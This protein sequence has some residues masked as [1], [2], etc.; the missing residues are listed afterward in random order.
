[1]FEWFSTQILVN[2]EILIQ[3]ETFPT[4]YEAQIMQLKMHKEKI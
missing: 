1:M 3:S 2:L 4:H